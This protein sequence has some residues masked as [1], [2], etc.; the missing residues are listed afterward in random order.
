MRY[1]CILIILLIFSIS[2][3]ADAPL[4]ISSII[5]IPSEESE[6]FL[7]LEGSIEYP[8]LCPV[9][10]NIISFELH[11]NSGIKLYWYNI[12]LDSL[13]E[14]VPP[15]LKQEG[16]DIF[17][18]FGMT[19]K[20]SVPNNFDLDWSPVVSPYREIIS[21]Y[22]H[23]QGDQQELYL[24][25]L[26]ENKHVRLNFR[27]NSGKSN[28]SGNSR[29]SPDGSM[30]AVGSDQS[31]KDEIY[32]ITGIDKY[33]SFPKK[34]SPG[35]YKIPIAEDYQ[36]EMSISW[37]PNIQSG[38]LA[39][40]KILENGNNEK[41]L[42]SSFVT[43]PDSLE[44][45]MMIKSDKN[46]MISSTWDPLYGNRIAFY[47]YKR[48]D[49]GRKNQSI[50]YNI[51]VRKV[52]KDDQGQIKI[53][54]ISD[55]PI[56]ESPVVGDTKNGP[57]WLENSN[58]ILYLQNDSQ[59]MTT[60][61]FA[62]LTAWAN[63]YRSGN[64]ELVLPDNF[65]NI[66]DLSYQR[67]QIAFVCDV[68]DSTHIVIGNL[69]GEGAALPLKSD[70][71]IKRHLRY[72]EFIAQFDQVPKESFLKRFAFNP[73]GGKDLIFNRPVVGLGIGALLMFLGNSSDEVPGDVNNWDDLPDPPRPGN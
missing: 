31:G 27:E 50:K 10:K 22:T 69:R 59:G 26:H 28:I 11:T 64:T 63:G 61:H 36:S 66:R 53:S 25:Y 41:Y 15:K 62:D 42:T 67:R 5:Q 37:N 19:I 35:F 47:S 65:Q 13:V 60:I 45:W 44:R 49:I 38:I 21:I 52:F 39:Y 57:I 1:F 68:K 43:L 20:K 18:E 55:I 16:S 6:S 2:G 29:W 9:D 48:D 56:N 30:I 4:E 24:Y 58:Y 73:V 46:N 51:N 34:F 8:K 40:T 71:K 70:F 33:L 3:W 12:S 72:A 32:L 17:E 14:I 7:G 23:A 54:S